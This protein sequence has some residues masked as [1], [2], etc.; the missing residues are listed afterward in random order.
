MN[1]EDKLENEIR[2]Y[3]GGLEY[4]S[5]QFEFNTVEGKTKLDVITINP[6][7][8]QRFLFHTVSGYDKEDA[9]KKMLDYVK[10]YKERESSYTVQ[11]SL[12]GENELHTSYFRAKNIWDALDKLTFGRDMNSII[13]YSVVLNPIS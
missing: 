1:L 5:L 4:D 8:K 11:W 10:N 6:V 12:R 3:I 7:H 13:V 9:L 2:S